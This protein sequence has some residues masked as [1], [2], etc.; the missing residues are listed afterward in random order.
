MKQPATP[1]VRW[2]GSTGRNRGCSGWRLGDT[3]QRGDPCGFLGEELS[4]QMIAEAP[5]RCILVIKNREGPSMAGGPGL[6]VGGRAAGPCRRM[7]FRGEI[8]QWAAVLRPQW[9]FHTFIWL[10]DSSGD[11]R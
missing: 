3:C 4:G 7:A 1:S 5:K 9:M 11:G 10:K 6:G 2:G 8:P